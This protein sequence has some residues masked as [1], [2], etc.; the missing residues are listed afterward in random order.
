MSTANDELVSQFMTVTGSSDP[1]RALSYIEMSGRNLETAVSL[2]L[3]HEGA[4]GGGRPDPSGYS[5]RNSLSASGHDTSTGVDDFDGVRAPDATQ[6]MRLMD[7]SHMG[8]EGLYGGVVGSRAAAAMMQMNPDFALMQ[9]FLDE[10]LQPSQM[11]AFAMSPTQLRSSTQPRLPSSGTNAAPSSF[12]DSAR[13]GSVPILSSAGSVRAAIAAMEARSI[14]SSGLDDHFGHDDNEHDEDEDMEVDGDENDE[15]DADR[16]HVVAP[17][18]LADLFAPP[19]HL[20][21]V[22]GGFQGARTVAKDSK[23]WLLV[24]IQRDEEFASH[25]LNRDVW[26]DELVENLVREGFIFWQEVCFW[27]FTLRLARRVSASHTSFPILG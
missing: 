6:T 18:R 25:T 23:R 7:D 17:P 15:D 4:G 1:D 22:A 8:A 10:Q 19:T 24:N 3:E 2:F 16:L 27:N 26:R 13:S 5:S 9:H 11:S 12:I 14:A 20:M 21:H